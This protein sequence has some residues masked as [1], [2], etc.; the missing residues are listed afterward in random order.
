MGYKEPA[1]AE[2]GAEDDG[3]ADTA[4]SGAPGVL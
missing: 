4:P 2:A 3:G 1:P